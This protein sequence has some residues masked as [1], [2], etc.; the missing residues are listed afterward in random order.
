MKCSAR[1]DKT[2]GFTWNTMRIKLNMAQQGKRIFQ[3][4]ATAVIIYTVRSKRVI[5]GV[6]F[7]LEN[8]VFIVAY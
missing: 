5:A 8:C 6:T 2:F 1:Q 4:A 3:I 7:A